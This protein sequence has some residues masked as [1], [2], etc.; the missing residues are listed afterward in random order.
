MRPHEQNGSGDCI[1]I[2]KREKP[3]IGDP[4]H[5]NRSLHFYTKRYCRCKHAVHE[6]PM[7][8]IARASKK[9]L[10]PR[11]DNSSYRTNNL[12]NAHGENRSKAGDRKPR[13]RPVQKTRKLMP[14]R[15]HDKRLQI[16]NNRMLIVAKDYTGGSALHHSSSQTTNK[17]VISSLP[18]LLALGAQPLPCLKRAAGQEPSRSHR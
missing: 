12:N 8:R 5:S 1:T 16:K 18:P 9:R 13:N 3:S 15:D 6:S 17:R 2:K 10:H 7:Q 4:K 14:S 11:L